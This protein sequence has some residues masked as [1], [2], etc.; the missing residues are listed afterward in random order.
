MTDTATTSLTDLIVRLSAARTE[1]GDLLG[2]HPYPQRYLLGAAVDA[3]KTTIKIIDHVEYDC[4]TRRGCD[5]P[6]EIIEP[7]HGKVKWRDG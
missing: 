3:L 2:T 5:S 4:R 7:W 6:A 1:L